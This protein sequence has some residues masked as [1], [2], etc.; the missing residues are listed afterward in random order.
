MLRADDWF[1]IALI[2]L[3]TIVALYDVLANDTE[4]WAAS[5][6]SQ[7]LW[8]AVV[9]LVPVFGPALYYVIARRR[10]NID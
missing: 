8:A 1:T 6:Q 4:V 3:P 9:V 10:L 5:N 7:S 2:L